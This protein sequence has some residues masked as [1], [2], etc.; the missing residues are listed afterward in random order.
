ME[1]I[2]QAIAALPAANPCEQRAFDWATRE[3]TQR[4]YDLRA[5]AANARQHEARLYAI[6]NSKDR[7]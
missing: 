4:G 7:P 6:L 2:L 5:V 1:I 3:L